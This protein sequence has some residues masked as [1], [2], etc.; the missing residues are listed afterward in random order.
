MFPIVLIAL[1]VLALATGATLLMRSRKARVTETLDTAGLSEE[2][3]IGQET[4]SNEEAGSNEIDEPAREEASPSEQIVTV[5]AAV[6]TS[7]ETGV[8][9]IDIDAE[10]DTR[11]ALHHHHH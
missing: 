7:P 6:L 5:E 10:S 11:L 1:G 3:E 9:R 2:I 4:S 8:I